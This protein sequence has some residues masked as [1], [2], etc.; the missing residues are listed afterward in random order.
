MGDG[1]N[2]F[3]VTQE[4]DYRSELNRNLK[5]LLDIDSI[6]AQNDLSEIEKYMVKKL[7]KKKPIPETTME[8]I[9]NNGGELPY[10]IA[11]KVRQKGVLIVRNTIP[12]NLIHSWSSDLLQYLYNNQAKE[13]NQTAYD[14]YWSKAQ[15]AA[16]QHPHM[17]KLQKALMKLWHT[18]EESEVDVNLD[19]PVMIADR[20]RIPRFKG[21]DNS[22]LDKTPRFEA[23]GISRWA[24]ATFRQVYRHILEGSWKDFDP[25]EVD[26]RLESNNPYFS[27][28]QGI[29]SMSSSEPIESLRVLPLL[30]E[31]IAYVML[32]PFA[33]DVPLN[34]FPGTF[35]AR[36]HVTENWHTPL[37]N[38]LVSIPPLG[39]G[40]TVWL[41]PDLIYGGSTQN[42]VLY[43]PIGPDCPINRHYLRKIRH[44]F[45]LGTTPPVSNDILVIED[46]E[47]DFKN[48]ATL[49]DL[50]DLGLS[51]FGL[52]PILEEVGESLCDA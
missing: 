4:L 40:D 33:P 50:S 10:R 17:F 22:T 20:L 18:N 29:L 14:I 19:K 52:Q 7:R 11:Q 36:F 47:V 23:G 26:Y 21:N 39:P 35:P 2:L 1:Q 8:K 49:E 9:L 43:I 32:R 28:F 12:R 45:V 13:N 46:Y 42:S 38:A 27:A 31:T 15:V 34:L 51:T 6:R 3:S 5:A 41:H 44:A 24:D 30:K 37:Y 25:F 16:R 48:R